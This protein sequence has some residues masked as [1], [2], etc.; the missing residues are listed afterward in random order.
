[1]SLWDALF[2]NQKNPADAAMPYLDKAGNALHQGYDKYAAIGDDPAAY[3]EKLM[4]AYKPSRSYGLRNE[5]AQRAAGNAAAAG[6]MRGS[7]NNS[8]NSA[9]IADS[10]LGE[11]M[12]QWL[13]NVFGQQ[14]LGYD[15][16]TGLAG[17]LANLYGQQ[18]QYSFQG[19]RE[20]NAGQNDF[21]KGLLGLAGGIGGTIFGPA[22]S[23]IGSALGTQVGNWL[24]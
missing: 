18:G 15:A 19:Q 3:L 10:L 2:G 20:Q 8:L 17:N 11:D 7:P 24:K 5:E 1:M 13:G 6:G 21:L 16:S 4:Q 9:R 14:K 22:G 12:Q 23:A